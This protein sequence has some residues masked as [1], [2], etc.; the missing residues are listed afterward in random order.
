MQLEGKRAPSWGG[1]RKELQ[2]SSPFQSRYEG[3]LPFG[4]D[5]VIADQDAKGLPAHPFLLNTPSYPYDD[6]VKK[7]YIFAP[8]RL[9][10]SAPASPNARQ[11][12]HLST[13]RRRHEK[14]TRPRISSPAVGVL[15]TAASFRATGWSHAVRT[16]EQGTSQQES[17]WLPKTDVGVAAKGER[18]CRTPWTRGS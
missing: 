7:F 9:R 13:P 10:A 8:A 11:H 14:A 16:E 12:R 6:M 1:G 3:F 2:G 18:P 15:F 4:G 17:G 5:H